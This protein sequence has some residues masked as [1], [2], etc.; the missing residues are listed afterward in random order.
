MPLLVVV[1]DDAVVSVC[2]VY[3]CEFAATANY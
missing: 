1:V 2:M 3:I